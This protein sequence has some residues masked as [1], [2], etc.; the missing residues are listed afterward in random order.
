MTGL[1]VR[2]T[3]NVGRL[4]DFRRGRDRRA[5]PVAAAVECLLIVGVAWVAW[6]VMQDDAPTLL[7][8]QFQTWLVISLVGAGVATLV[9]VVFW[10]SFHARLALAGGLV[11]SVV[12][13]LL[14]LLNDILTSAS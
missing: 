4:S 6:Q 7:D 3:G 10:R 13:V 14:G 1:T 5:V 11:L 12:L 2:E 8:T 9:G